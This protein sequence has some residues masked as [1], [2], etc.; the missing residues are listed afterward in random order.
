MDAREGIEAAQPRWRDPGCDDLDRHRRGCVV[1][2]EVR[3]LVRRSD[4]RERGTLLIDAAA[5]IEGVDEFFE[6]ADDHGDHGM[7]R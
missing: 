2:V 1:L 5:E 6:E 4:V 3:S 7:L